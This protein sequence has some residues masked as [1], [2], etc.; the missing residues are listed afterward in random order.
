MLYDR[1]F[2][3]TTY[4]T[5]HSSGR[6]TGVYKKS[7]TTRERADRCRLSPRYRPSADVRTTPNTP[8]L[9]RPPRLSNIGRGQYSDGRPPWNTGEPCWRRPRRHSPCEPTADRG[10]R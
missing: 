6:R 8:A 4:R 7:V 1:K 10:V 2:I 3:A 5:L 9:G